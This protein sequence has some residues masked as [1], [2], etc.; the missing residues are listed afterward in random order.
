MAKASKVVPAQLGML[1][2]GKQTQQL[3]NG[4]KQWKGLKNKEELKKQAKIAT[5]YSKVH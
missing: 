5:K 4:Y 3:L 1:N 2:Y